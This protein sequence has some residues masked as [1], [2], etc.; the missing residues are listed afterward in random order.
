LKTSFSIITP[1]LNAE[2]EILS[3]LEN[4][5]ARG[6][7]S[8]CSFEH[9]VIDGGSTDGTVE[10]IRNFAAS[11]PHVRW[12]SE[13]YTT[14]G[15]AG[16]KALKL[17]K[18]EVISWLGISDSYNPN[19]LGIVAEFFEKTPDLAFLFG[20]YNKVRDDGSVVSSVSAIYTHDDDLI[21]YWKSWDVDLKLPWQSTFYR[22][23]VHDLLGPY[24]NEL[25]NH[26][27]EFLLR[28]A[29]HFSFLCV[30]ERLTNSRNGS[31]DELLQNHEREKEFL[32][33]SRNYWGSPG[34]KSKLRYTLSRMLHRNCRWLV[35][36][37]Y[38][39]IKYPLRLILKIAKVLRHFKARNDTRGFF[40]IVLETPPV[41]VNPQSPIEIHTVCCHKDVF[42]LLLSLKSLLRYFSDVRVVVHDDGTFTEDDRALF[43]KHISGAEIFALKVNSDEFDEHVARDF[44]VNKAKGVMNHIKGEKVIM[45][46]SDMLF[47]SKP[48]EIVDWITG[49][50]TCRLYGPDRW[51]NH[52]PYPEIKKEFNRTYLP[53]FFN[54]GLMCLLGE[55]FDWQEFIS[56]VERLEKFDSVILVEQASFCVTFS[57]KPHMS[58]PRS[59]Y[60]PCWFPHTELGK[61]EINKDTAHLHFM[62]PK[63][64]MVN[65][66]YREHSIR[67]CEELKGAD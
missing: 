66:L 63:D 38:S 57:E 22:K 9:L 35:E 3:C 46:D 64:Y 39:L 20:S 60:V 16:N 5:A 25:N 37:Y 6:E 32:I 28:A 49:D 13:E 59:R 10:R 44:W 48:H 23:S 58:L 55:D 61:S 1:V 24:S 45:L 14:L 19:T 50:G 18:N 2:D 54:A 65:E 26:E 56:L 30:A 31:K 7:E 4:I 17:A 36:C 67:V 41:E 12:V 33:A 52:N 8:G 21:E 42:M 47:T 27:Y 11:H 62:G 15:E 34:R 29:E 40:S 43:K 51:D 53:P